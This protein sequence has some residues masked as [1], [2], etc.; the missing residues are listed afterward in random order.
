VVGA[1]LLSPATPDANDPLPAAIDFAQPS[2]APGSYVEL[3]PDDL[4]D[5]EAAIARHDFEGARQEAEATSE[6][7]THEQAALRLYGSM[8]DAFEQLDGRCDLIGERVAQLVDEQGAQLRAE[9]T[10]GGGASA[11]W[12]PS[13][14]RLDASAQAQLERFRARLRDTL[15]KCGGDQAL[16][17]ALRELSLLASS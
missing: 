1:R 16:L 17:G 4:V 14:R 13:E 3:A 9:R 8:L 6:L 5:A 2:A 15:G 12:A 7:P 10:T 11:R